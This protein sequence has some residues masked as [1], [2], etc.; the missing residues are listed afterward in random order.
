MDDTHTERASERERESACDGSL[1]VD[2]AP[3]V[4]HTPL[5]PLCLQEFSTAQIKS[6]FHPR[7]PYDPL[8]AV[9]G[10]F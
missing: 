10:F 2:F 1:R 7:F 9:F 6:N 3:Q 5:R 8:S 4:P